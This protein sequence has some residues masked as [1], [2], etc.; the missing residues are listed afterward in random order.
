MFVSPFAGS[1]P[2][3]CRVQ[4]PPPEKKAAPKPSKSNKQYGGPG[5]F[6]P[7]G[8]LPSSLATSHGTQA[9]RTMST[10]GIPEH[11]RQVSV[12]DSLRASSSLAKL[13]LYTPPYE[14]TNGPQS[15]D[16]I[17]SDFGEL[18]VGDLRRRESYPVSINKLLHCM[19]SI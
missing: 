16:S 17:A 3:T 4:E 6:V 9:S 8:E 5:S 7:S 11:A 14:R 18:R 19:F 12:P 1:S 15:V 2:L 10:S 13:D